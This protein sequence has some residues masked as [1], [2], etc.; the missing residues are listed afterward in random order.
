MVQSTALFTEITVG[1]MGSTKTSSNNWLRMANIAS[2]IMMDQG[3]FSGFPREAMLRSIQR[4]V[5]KTQS[6]R[7]LGLFWV[8]HILSIVRFQ[9]CMNFLRNA[10]ETCSKGNLGLFGVFRIFTTVR[11]QSGMNILR[12]TPK[13]SSKI[14]LGLLWRIQIFSTAWGNSIFL[15]EYLFV[16]PANG[17]FTCDILLQ[18]SLIIYPLRS[19]RCKFFRKSLKKFFAVW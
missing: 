19:L 5:P 16:L 3:G 10:P 14:N 2:V 17:R 18:W 11:F 1:Q 12:N 8:I 13:T 15:V 4:N 6:K 7:N 9:S